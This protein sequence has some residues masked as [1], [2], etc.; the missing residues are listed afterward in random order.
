MIAACKHKTVGSKTHVMQ[1]RDFFADNCH[2]RGVG[3]AFTL[4]KTTLGHYLQRIF[5]EKKPRLNLR[6]QLMAAI[7]NSIYFK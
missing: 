5:S 6:R 2:I 1:C 4:V 3:K 7:C